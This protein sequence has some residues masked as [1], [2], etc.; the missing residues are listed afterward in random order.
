MTCSLN[1][2]MPRRVWN[3]FAGFSGVCESLNQ[4]L[5]KLL[6]ICLDYNY[7][8]LLASITILIK[9]Y[10]FKWSNC[11]SLCELSKERLSNT[12]KWPIYD[13][14]SNIPTRVLSCLSERVLYCNNDCLD[15]D[16]GVL[17]WRLEIKVCAYCYI[18]IGLVR[19]M[20]LGV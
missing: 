5:F 19:L 4:V 14:D 8:S 10:N 1:F 2:L 12:E 9:S 13:F 7:L 6:M 11:S 18:K 3:L 15:F 17:I 16:L 20:L